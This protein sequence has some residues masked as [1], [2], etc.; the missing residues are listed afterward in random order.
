MALRARIPAGL[1][2]CCQP[3]QWGRV[4]QAP[5]PRAGLSLGNRGPQIASPVRANGKRGCSRHRQGSPQAPSPDPGWIETLTVARNRGPHRIGGGSW[6]ARGG[7]PAAD[8]RGQGWVQAWELG[9]GGGDPGRPTHLLAAAVEG[10]LHLPPRLGHVALLEQGE[11]VRVLE[12]DFQL[13][14]LHLL[15]GAQ[16]VLGEPAWGRVGHPSTSGEPS[17]RGSS[18]QAAL[19]RHSRGHPPHSVLQPQPLTQTTTAGAVGS[20]LPC[21]SACSHLRNS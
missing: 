14:I 11:V 18:L 16:E 5:F 4:L 12:R 19:P 13:A 17:W 10:L 3:G 9:A 15:K 2:C 1:C 7:H 20:P 6:K 8:G 21:W